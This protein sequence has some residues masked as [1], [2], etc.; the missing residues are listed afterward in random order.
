VFGFLISC[1]LSAR[2]IAAAAG[3]VDR[4]TTAGTLAAVEKS[5]DWQL[6]SPT[7]HKPT[8]WVMGAFYTGLLAVADVSASPRFHEAMVRIGD[9]NEWNLGPAT[10]YNAD[11]HCV[12]QSY[13]QLCLDALA[14]PAL[15]AQYAPSRRQRWLAPM[16]ETFDYVLA[17][18]LD[19][20]LDFD[21]KRNPNRTDR[22][23]WCDALYM[24]PPGW[25]RLW[26]ITA[27]QRY[28]DFMVKKWWV[29][30][31]F[32][33]DKNEHLYFRDSTYFPPKA[34]ANGKKIFWSRGNGW[35]MGGLA[36]V[37]RYFPDDHPA[38]P[39]FEKQFRDMAAKV[40]T[41]QQS[42]G[43]WRASLLDPASFP[44]KE[45]SGTGFFTYALAW[46]I[47]NGLLDRATYEPHVAKGWAALLSCQESS[48]R[49]THVQ[50]IAGSPKAFKDD[51]SEPYGVGAFLLAGCEVYKLIQ[52]N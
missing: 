34:E 30:S 21:K 22:W 44:S 32:L 5:A 25:L 28:L 37:L 2:N 18:P 26:K 17:N 41:C 4:F 3:G 51:V 31:D 40:I 8:G 46:G 48:G 11:E 7:R 13:A 45:A 15:A 24:A 38:R 10:R 35:V 6:A 50:S 1:V 20:N 23:S 49:I 42:D 16:R 12:G 19:D 52:K 33:Y 14:D 43:F 47:N 39:R 9:G 36:R 27:D 29:T